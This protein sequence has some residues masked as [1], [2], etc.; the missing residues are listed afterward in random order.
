M[1]ESLIFILNGDVD[2][3]SADILEENSRIKEQLR[4]LEKRH[5]SVVDKLTEERDAAQKELD[6]IKVMDHALYFEPRLPLLRKTE[7]SL[8]CCL[9]HRW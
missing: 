8:P 2:K 9:P 6:F 3:L 4:Q 7:R 5:K 1:L